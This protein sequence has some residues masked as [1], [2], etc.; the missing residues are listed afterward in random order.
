MSSKY[1]ISEKVA[2][3]LEESQLEVLRDLRLPVDK[4]L[5][6]NLTGEQIADLDPKLFA[7]ARVDESAAERTGYSNYSYWGSTV[8]MFMK[9]RVA[10]ANLIIMLLL[11]LFTFIQPLLP[12]QFDP[13][14][15]NYYADNAVWYVVDEDGSYTADSIKSTRGAAPAVPGEDEVLVYISVPE[16]WK[17][18]QA[19]AAGEEGDEKTL[20]VMSDPNDSGWYYAITDKEHAHIRILSE[21]GGDSTFYDAVWLRVK[22]GNK[23]YTES[24]KQTK[25]DII[26]DL[27]DG[28][29]LVYLE[30]PDS[31]GTPVLNAATSITSG[32]SEEVGMQADPENKGWFYGFFPSDKTTLSVASEDGS[33]KGANITM[34][35]AGMPAAFE[36]K[37]GFIENRR[38]NSVFWF[39]TN[40]IGQDLWSRMW[41]GTRTSLF[42]G[43]V[44]ALIEAVVGILAGL[45]WGY[46]RSLDFLFTE[47]YNLIDNIPTTIIQILAAYVLRPS[48]STIIIAMS[49]TGWIGLARFIRNQ[50][51]IIRDRDFN[52]AS[53]CLGTPTRRVINKN[54]LPQMVSVVML[55]MAL[56]IP[57][58]IGSEVFLSYIGLG[59]PINVPSLGNLVNKG[60]T[61]MMSPTLRYQL[62]I[63]A[64][65]LSIITICFYLVGNA[66][67]DAADPKNHV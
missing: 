13:N 36:L 23:L 61:L 57:G 60:R 16:S 3:R 45:L 55:R 6:D 14:T 51:L 8:R 54:L 4:L 29:S 31:W 46:V 38:P 32:D 65:I 52:L 58:A 26:T 53:R 19:F 28:K 15:V 5:D 40:D 33:Q 49:I 63:P 56:A 7:E 18:P 48:M 64:I 41:S 27:P 21:S 12:N 59:L 67:S 17:R 34:V 62:F 24:S 39:G 47:L 1:A 42:I 66:F 50:V 9:N 22:D 20:E 2:R 37:S 35:Q 43:I 25:G 11:V 30:V 44:V 10:V